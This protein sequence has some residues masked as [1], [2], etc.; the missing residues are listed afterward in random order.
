MQ[1]ANGRQP[2]HHR[3]HSEPFAFYDDYLTPSGGGS[4]GHYS[5]E[6][7]HAPLSRRKSSVGGGSH[8]PSPDL[9]PIAEHGP[10]RS[11]GT[12]GTKKSHVR[13]HSDMHQVTSDLVAMS[14][15][16]GHSSGGHGRRTS[17]GSAGSDGTSRS[18]AASSSSGSRL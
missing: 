7:V 8:V 18:G 14:L 4:T 11:R 17:S 12:S 9:A 6:M 3:S 5:G 13:R 16:P 10:S 2:R 15:V 1:Y